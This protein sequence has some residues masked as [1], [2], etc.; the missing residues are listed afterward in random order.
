LPAYKPA[1]AS[2]LKDS[3][4]KLS[5]VAICYVDSLKLQLLT[6]FTK[7]PLNKSSW[8]DIDFLGTCLQG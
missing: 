1:I 8:I 4:S 5:C 6:Q 2:F 7:H 3:K